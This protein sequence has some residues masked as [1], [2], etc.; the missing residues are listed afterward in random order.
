MLKLNNAILNLLNVYEGQPVIK[1]ETHLLLSFKSVTNAV[2]AA[3]EIQLLLKE[4]EHDFNKDKILLKIGLSAGVPV[5]EKE[6]IFEDTIKLAER[7]CKVIRGQIIVS[8][9]V[10]ELYNS[11]NSNT[12]FDG[13]NINC[14]T[15]ADECQFC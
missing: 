10:K 5:T 3:Y 13:E 8:S 11:E 9:E 6:L 4:F 14:L 12:L 2:Q 1:K 7:M 15:Q